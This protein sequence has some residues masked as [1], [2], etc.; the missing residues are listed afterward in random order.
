M[1]YSTFEVISILYSLHDFIIYAYLFFVFV[2][3]QKEVFVLKEAWKTIPYWLAK[4][5]LVTKNKLYISQA[6]GC[7]GENLS[8]IF[9]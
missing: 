3:Y 4:T 7:K 2:R 5:K 8:L 6:K 1:I 9:L